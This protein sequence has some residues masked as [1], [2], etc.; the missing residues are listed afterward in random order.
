MRE[1]W[2]I[3]ACMALIEATTSN[4]SDGLV[5]PDVE[6]EFFC[7]LGD[8]YSLARVKVKCLSHEVTKYTKSIYFSLTMA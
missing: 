3:T 1:V 7:L 4:Y 2:V 8:L 6:K 5:A